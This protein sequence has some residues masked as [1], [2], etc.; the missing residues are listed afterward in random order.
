MSDEKP[1]H[2]QVAEKLGWSLLGPETHNLPEYAEPQT[3]WF[4]HP[5][6]NACPVWFTDLD[7]P[8]AR[9]QVPDYACD[10][11]ATGP[12]IERLGIELKPSS[13]PFS[14]GQWLA[15]LRVPSLEYPII[16]A[17]NTESVGATPLLAICNLILALPDAVVR[18][19]GSK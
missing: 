2:V 1:L 4:G 12:L 16:L 7:K 6:P 10:W 13:E 17:F 9:A 18:E 3:N 14:E 19:G 11:S 8:K 5:T 15:A